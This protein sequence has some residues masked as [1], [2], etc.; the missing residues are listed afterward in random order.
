[1]CHQ[2][3]APHNRAQMNTKAS[4]PYYLKYYLNLESTIDPKAY[5]HTAY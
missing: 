3:F 5:I 1:M 4:N 2:M